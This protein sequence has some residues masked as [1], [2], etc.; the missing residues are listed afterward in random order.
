MSDPFTLKYF[1]LNSSFKEEPRAVLPLPVLPYKSTP[2]GNLMGTDLKS[3]PYLIGF[4]IRLFIVFLAYCS[5]ASLPKSNFS[6]L[7]FVC[8]CD[9][10]MACLEYVAK[11]KD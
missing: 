10:W 5:P 8:G 6:E 7:F 4:S 11:G 9:S 1:I 3:A 2:L